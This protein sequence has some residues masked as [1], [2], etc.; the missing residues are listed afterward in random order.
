MVISP[1]WPPGAD[2]AKMQKMGQNGH[3]SEL[4]SRTLKIP[5][6]IVFLP[7]FLRKRVFLGILRVTGWPFDQKNGSNFADFELK[8]LVVSL[9]GHK[10]SNNGANIVMLY[11]FGISGKR[12]I[13]KNGLWAKTI[14]CV[15]LRGQSL[16]PQKSDPLENNIWYSKVGISWTVHPFYYFST[17]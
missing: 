8:I 17:R 10:S 13:R 11:I 15:D 14:I 4:V 7:R 12:R 6:G 9:E 5:L 16:T 1:F 3:I 2:D